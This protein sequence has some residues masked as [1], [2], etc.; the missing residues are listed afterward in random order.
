MTRPLS[1]IPVLLAPALFASSLLPA[2]PAVAG[3]P[4]ERAVAQ[5]RAEMLSQF[6]EGTVRSYR[7]AEVAGNSRGTRI[8][9]RLT[10][11]RN[12]RFD[13]RA[14]ADGRVEVA[15]IDPPRGGEPQLAAGQR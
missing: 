9:F 7:L 11:D 4:A 3:G 8:T 13:C 12:Y 2:A 10:A 14:G 1:L 5:C 6:P 15:S